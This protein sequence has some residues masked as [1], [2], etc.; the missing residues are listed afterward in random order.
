MKVS[1]VLVLVSLVLGQHTV[2]SASRLPANESQKSINEIS[3]EMERLLKEKSEMKEALLH[4]KSLRNIS[5]VVVV[6]TAA[7]TIGFAGL[8]F[9]SDFGGLFRSAVTTFDKF[10]VVLSKNKVPFYATATAIGLGSS[11]SLVYFNINANDF[12]RTIETLDAQTIKLQ[13][14]LIA[15]KSLN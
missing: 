1:S 15:L 11:A 14:D 10:T 6:A 8:T 12:A 9:I 4:A 2:S 3:N 13:Q 5:T 7:V